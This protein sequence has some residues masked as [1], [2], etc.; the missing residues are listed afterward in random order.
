V[1]LAYDLRNTVLTSGLDEAQLEELV[2]AGDEVTFGRGDLLFEEGRPANLLWVLLEG[3]VELSRRI[4]HEKMVLTTMTVPGQWAGGLAAWGD[5]DDPAG[6]RASGTAV[7]AGR[8][9]TVSARDLARLVEAWSPFS[10]H[11]LMG[12][13][14][15]VRNIDATA[16][17]RES[18]VALG[19]LAAGLAH[20]INNP[21]AA[22][23]RTVESLR[24]TNGY[25]LAALVELAEDGVTAEQFIELDRLRVDLQDREVPD[26]DD[27]SI[28]AADREEALGSWLEARAIDPAW[29]MAAVFASA[30]VEPG[31]FE[32][33]EAVSGHVALGPA[34]RWVSSTIGAAALMAEITDATTRIGHLVKDVKSYSQMDRSALQVVDLHEGISSTLAILKPKLEGIDVV[35]SFDP[36]LPALEVYA[37]ELNQLWTNLIDNAVDAMAG[38]G[39]LRL[40]T[41]RDGDD[42]VIEVVDSGPGM[43]PEVQA[44]AF[45]PFFTTKDVGQGTGLG[46]D[47]SRRIVVDRHGGSITIDSIPGATTVRVRLP[48]RR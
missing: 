2:A 7:S 37:S 1:T 12:V 24:A 8:F 41:A 33:V 14:Q 31:W 40:V 26:D 18:L 27:G 42:V 11:L 3:E 13:F 10:K 9:F 29:S 17:Q 43:P 38:K 5:P 21:A 46:L 34:L 19:T 32:Q 28:A 6:Y 4:G 15:T 44:R 22:V 35:R 47:I 30:G 45:E 25:M 20:E 36:D 16:R 23:L 39:T 48:V